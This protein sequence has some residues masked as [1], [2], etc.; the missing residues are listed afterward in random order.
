MI[1]YES[2]LETEGS[3]YSCVICNFE[4]F[5]LMSDI[6]VAT[7]LV[8]YIKDVADKFIQE[9]YFRAIVNVQASSE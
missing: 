5:R 1:V 9:I 6:I 8:G 7:R 3:Y 2:M 4:E